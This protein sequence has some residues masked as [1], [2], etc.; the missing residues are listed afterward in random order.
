MKKNSFNLKER[1]NQPN[2]LE[3]IK[4]YLLV[5][6]TP[7]KPSRKNN[8][9]WKKKNVVINLKLIKL[10]RKLSKKLAKKAS[11]IQLTGNPLK[12]SN[13]MFSSNWKTNKNKSDSIPFIPKWILSARKLIAVLAEIVLNPPGINYCTKIIKR[14]K[15]KKPSSEEV[16]SWKFLSNLR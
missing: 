2:W 16:L 10:V 3:L 1:K 8:F 6:L 9:G 14:L 12:D 4:S 7:T 11:L 15:I 5:G 13:S